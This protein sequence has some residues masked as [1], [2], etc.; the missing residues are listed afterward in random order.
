MSNV[1]SINAARVEKKMQEFA[2]T[3]GPPCCMDE[4]E[5]DRAEAVR[6]LQRED[7]RRMALLQQEAQWKRDIKQPAE[8]HWH[9]NPDF[10][11]T[12]G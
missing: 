7:A 4:L 3:Y 9:R 8:T 6:E 11:T 2:E 10:Y 12:E 1:I 5:Y